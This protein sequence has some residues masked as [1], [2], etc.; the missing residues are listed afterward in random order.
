[1]LSL[2]TNEYEAFIRQHTR[3]QRP[4][5]VPELQLYPAD[6]LWPLW[7]ATEEATGR[8]GGPPP[9]WAFAWAGGLALARY[10]LDHPAVA[11]GQRVLDFATGSGLCA[12]AAMRAG[13][14]SALAAD[15]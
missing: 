9:F 1:M 4:P 3:L 6:A 7:R 11:A 5:F 13:A 10:L 14:A 2:M 8:R 12:I 15:I